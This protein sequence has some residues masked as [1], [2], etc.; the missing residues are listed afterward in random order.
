MV[1]WGK[2][3][4]KI[5]TYRPYFFGLCYRKQTYFLGGPY[6]QPLT[7]FILTFS[8]SVLFSGSEDHGI[9]SVGPELKSCISP[10]LIALS[11]SWESQRVK[12]IKFRWSTG[13]G[14]DQ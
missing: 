1:F 14:S 11:V 2:K 4:K 7:F 3:R 12:N 10:N 8:Q 6:P 5:P 13:Q 9:R